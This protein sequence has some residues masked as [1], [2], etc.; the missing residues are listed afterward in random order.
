MFTFESPSRHHQ[1]G[2][3]T[4]IKSKT[5]G[6]PAHRSACTFFRYHN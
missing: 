6:I 1:S 5:A 3:I 4:P 2:N